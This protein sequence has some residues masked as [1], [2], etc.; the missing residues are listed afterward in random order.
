MKTP[1]ATTARSR[2]QWFIRR[3]CGDLRGAELAAELRPIR[4]D[5]MVR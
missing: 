4:V 3:G 2:T 5:R 1:D